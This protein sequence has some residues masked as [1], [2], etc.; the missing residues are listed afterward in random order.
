[1]RVLLTTVPGIEDAV[2][3]EVKELF[4]DRVVTAEVFGSSNVT[5][6]VLIDINNVTINELK[7]LGTVEHV[8]MV[9]DIKNVG[10]DMGSLRDCIWKLRLDELLNYYTVN[11]TIGIM[12]DRSGDHEFKSPDAAALLGERISEFLMSM[13]LK[14]LFNLD[15]ADLTLRLI[16]DQD[17]C[18]LGLSITRKPLRNRPY[19]KFN[20]PASINPILANA[21]FR[22]LSPAPSSRICDVTCGSGT[23]VIEGALMRRDVIFL[24]ADIDYGYV[25]GAL[26][27]ARE[28]NVDYLIDF[29]VMDSTRPAIR[30]N[31][32]SYAIFNPPFGIR[33]EPLKGIADFYGSLFRA[34]RNV[35]RD[36]SSMVFIT[37]RKSLAKKLLVKYGFRIVS[38]RVVEQGGIWSSIFKVVK[39]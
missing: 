28:A 30:D 21:M 13:G 11:T 15:N 32:C 37:V 33:I 36:G 22:I 3:S 5:G 38:E 31:A 26:A 2:I 18:V 14:S 4:K 27:N 25:N 19:R 7:A 34:L 9:L 35:L 23:I 1:M 24:C 29:V 10:R 6:K 39:E 16:I 17:K 8:V 20:H 12:A